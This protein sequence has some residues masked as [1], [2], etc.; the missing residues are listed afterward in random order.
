MG[1]MLNIQYVTE[2][3]VSTLYHCLVKFI[4]GIN[5]NGNAVL[6]CNWLIFQNV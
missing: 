2:G 4:W 6:N 5:I 1:T 3:N